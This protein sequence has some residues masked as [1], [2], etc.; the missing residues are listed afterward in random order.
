MPREMKDK[1]DMLNR[2]THIAESDSGRYSETNMRRLYC[3]RLS[4]IPTFPPTSLDVPKAAQQCLPIVE[5]PER[6][7]RTIPWLPEKICDDLNVSKVDP[8][9]V[10]ALFGR[11]L[12]DLLFLQC[13]FDNI[14]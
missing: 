14:Q 8:P 5:F 12:Q 6:E 7:L 9:E 10:D 2:Q 1:S 3:H 11:E 4:N 13:I